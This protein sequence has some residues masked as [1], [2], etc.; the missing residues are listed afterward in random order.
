[1]IEYWDILDCENYN[2]ERA[3]IFCADAFQHMNCIIDETV[4]CIIT[5]P[6]Y[7]TLDKWR[8]VGTTTRL[9]GNKDPEKRKGW[10]S[11]INKDQLWELM[12]GMFRV[13]RND[14]HAYLMCD[15]ETLRY[16][17][18]YA[19]D[20]DWRYYKPLVWDKVNQGMGYH[21]RARYE[22]I[23]FL[24]KGKRRLNDLSIPDI[25]I[26]KKESGGYPTR[27][28]YGLMATLVA[29]STQEGETVYDPFMGSGTTG[30]A[31]VD[32]G[33]FFVGCDI[34]PAAFSIARENLENSQLTMPLGG[35]KLA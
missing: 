27:K 29:Q 9:G 28:P 23:L 25:L 32:T 10:F 13:L 3:E 1:M 18:A 24:E 31:A 35:K 34:S 7:W 14:S 26:H 30:Q 4:D 20:M 6:P 19:D 12:N 5:D 11:T 17:L 21:Y 8:E 33:R 22:F 15:H 2:G 16:A